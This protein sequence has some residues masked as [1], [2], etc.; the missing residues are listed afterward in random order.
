MGSATDLPSGIS[1]TEFRD[2][3]PAGRNHVLDDED[4]ITSI[5]QDEGVHNLGLRLNANIVGFVVNHLARAQ[6]ARQLWQ[7]RQAIA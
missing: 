2:R 1:Y 5:S 6:P 3:A 4:L 7:R